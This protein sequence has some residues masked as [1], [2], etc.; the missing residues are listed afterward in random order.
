MRSLGIS[1]LQG[2]EVQPRQSI[3]RALTSVT[4]QGGESWGNFPAS[5]SYSIVFNEEFVCVTA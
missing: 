2:G 3:F 1:A 4:P 5:G